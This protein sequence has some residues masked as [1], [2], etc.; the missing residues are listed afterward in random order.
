MGRSVRPARRDCARIFAFG[1]GVRPI[2]ELN[3]PPDRSGR[4]RRAG[5]FA[6]S[7][8]LHAVLVFGAFRHKGTYKI[9]ALDTNV[10]QAFLV[11]REAVRYQAA[12]P[13]RRGAAAPAVPPAPGG[14]SENGAVAPTAGAAAAPG[15]AVSGEAE[16]AG[17]SS[18]GGAATGAPAAAGPGGGFRLTYPADAAR[19]SLTRSASAIEDTLV[20]PGL[21]RDYSK[22]NL[23]PGEARSG[24]GE[25]RTVRQAAARARRSAGPGG[26]AVKLPGLDFKP[27]GTEVLE[28]IQKN[29]A[30]P[31]GSGSAWKGE[32]GVRVTVARDGQVLGTDLDAPSKIDIL[33][34]A[35]MKAVAAASPFPALPEGYPSSSLEVYFVF[36]YGD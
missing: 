3:A 14:A 16:T 27:W 13:A 9:F 20:S 21:Y 6:L 22:A 18:G 19:I 36:R 10:R 23:S 4:V 2:F 17:G 15:Q 8:A 30:L 31:G 35:A 11:P 32:V 1:Q 12:R 28:K 26:V 24:T 29:W 25:G 34:Q 5:L 33:D 7:A